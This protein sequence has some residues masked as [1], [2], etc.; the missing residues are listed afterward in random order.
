ML[1]S[2]LFDGR[3][4]TAVVDAVI[5]GLYDCGQLS[6]AGKAID[7]AVQGKISALLP[8]ERS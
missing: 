7:D 8:G 6:E 4:D 3:L 5:V 2:Q 1:T